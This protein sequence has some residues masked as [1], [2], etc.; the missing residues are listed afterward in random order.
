M[1]RIRLRAYSTAELKTEIARRVSRVK[2]LYATRRRLLK[3]LK[4]VEAELAAIGET[5]NSSSFDGQSS[6]AGRRHKNK[7]NLVDVMARVMQGKEPL[8]VPEIAKAVKRAGYRSQSR[9]FRS[10][11]VQQL[12]KDERFR[13]VGRGQYVLR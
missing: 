11:I 1:K 2:K 7:A 6:A 9:F 12:L 3:H 4:K 5:L 8:R 13:R 10:M